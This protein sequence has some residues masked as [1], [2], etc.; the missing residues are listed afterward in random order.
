MHASSGQATD[1]TDLLTA[2]LLTQPQM[3]GSA[4]AR[5]D[6]FSFVCHTWQFA[7][8]WQTFVQTEKLLLVLHYG[9]NIQAAQA[10]G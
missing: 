2:L 9:S 6:A 10:V 8:A 5:H 7:R 3:V 4:S 1:I